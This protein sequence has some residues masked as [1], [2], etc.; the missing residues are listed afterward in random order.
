MIN[1]MFFLINKWKS[2]CMFDYEKIKMT[3]PNIFTEAI[4][5][6]FI[7]LINKFTKDTPALWG[8]M[9][10][11]KIIL[12]LLCFNTCFASED[13]TYIHYYNCRN[14]AYFHFYEQ[15][16]KT[17]K[18][19][20]EKAFSLKLTPFELDEYAYAMTLSELGDTTK[21]IE[22]LTTCKLA[23]KIKR[24]TNYFNNISNLTKEKLISK[25]EK[26]MKQFSDS[27][28]NSEIKL[29]I[30]RLNEK[31]QQLRVYLRDSIEP[32]FHLDS[33][34]YQSER[35]SIWCLDEKN[36][37]Q[38]DSIYKLYGFI[39]Q[40][41]KDFNYNE[42]DL[43]TFILHTGKEYYE[44]NKKFLLGEVKKGRLSPEWYAGGYDRFYMNSD[45]NE[46]YGFYSS[47]F[48]VTISPEE[49]FSRLIS[50]GISPYLDY[51]KKIRFKIYEKGN[52]PKFKYYDYYKA[53]KEKFNACR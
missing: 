10:V 39:G 27:V 32:Y 29:Y 51:D 16:F 6:Q 8:K 2:I 36:I 1:V 14:E 38:I 20:F 5:N 43:H 22:I 9:N 24:D 52:I 50:L 47:R 18:I 35:D 45:L 44:S 25:G 30:H 46:Y 11:L 48:E 13:T 42:V 34:K 28:T 40:G 12:F 26:A 31:D 7:E 3:N 17:A 49:Y 53:N 23:Y 37:Q 33:L 21:A 19:Y 41:P 4:S 15:D